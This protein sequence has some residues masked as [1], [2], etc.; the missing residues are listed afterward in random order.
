MNIA[1]QVER[2]KRFWRTATDP[3]EVERT[4]ERLRWLEEFAFHCGPEITP[5]HFLALEG[6]IE[7][8]E[9]KLAELR[10]DLP[11]SAQRS[12]NPS[13]PEVASA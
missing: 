5:Q 9:R 3:A 6:Q 1:T 10:G 11:Q 12:K 8:G 2:W 13:A 4:L 7:R